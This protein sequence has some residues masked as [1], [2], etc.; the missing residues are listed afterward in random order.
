MKIKYLYTLLVVSVITLVIFSA[1]RTE[2]VKGD[3]KRNDQVI[4]FSHKVHSEVGDCQSCHIKVQDSE[5][6]KDITFPNHEQCSQCHDVEDSEN[7]NT[8]HINENYEPLMKRSSELIFNH[9]FHSADQKLECAHCHRGLTDVDYSFQAIQP[10]PPMETC[11]SCHNSNGIAS[12]ACESCHI[13]T[14]ALRPESHQKVNFL[15]AHKFD[16]M[17]AN[18]NCAMC[19]DNNSCDD[20]HVSTTML[21]EENTSDDFYAPY[22]PHN[23]VDGSKQQKI[24]RVHELNYRF[25]HGVDFRNKTTNCQTC[26]QLETFCAECHGSNGGDFAL[27]DITPATHRQPGFF[28][29]GVG[30]GGGEHAVLAKR[31]IES[32]ASCHDIQGGDPSCMTCHMDSDGIEGTNPKTHPAN[33]MKDEKGDWHETTAS[34]CY[35]CHTSA[36]PSSSPESGFCRYCHS[37]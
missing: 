35:N 6:L 23:F 16:A 13:S 33:F 25:M 11:N 37:N 1:F 17:S 30:T 24:T 29:F 32:C 36:S 9:K 15:K 21:T 8:C 7:C 2:D 19:H 14:A 31:D 4:K 10:F 28:T 18:A 3:E 26:H 34:L 27:T 20:C 22:A 5:S 12:N